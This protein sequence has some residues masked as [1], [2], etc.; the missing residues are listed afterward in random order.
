MHY[1][2]FINETQEVDFRVRLTSDTSLKLQ[3]SSVAKL[4]WCVVAK[5]ASSDYTSLAGS[6]GAELK[7]FKEFAHRENF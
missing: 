4:F 2:I 1:D 7:I 6:T 3:F 5:L